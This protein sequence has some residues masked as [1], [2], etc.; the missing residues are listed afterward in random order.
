MVHP[1]F[2]FSHATILGFWPKTFL[3]YAHYLGELTRNR[4]LLVLV[5]PTLV[6][7]VL[8]LALA[9]SGLLPPSPLR[10][11]AYYTSMANA[12]GAGGDVLGCWLL[13]TQVR[14]TS[15]VQNQGWRTY[16]K[17]TRLAEV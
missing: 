13:L 15:L 12:T 14:R 16:W 8:P 4:V 3:G 6:L 10:M 5:M 17:P 1:K 9:A 11:W 2:G 7:T